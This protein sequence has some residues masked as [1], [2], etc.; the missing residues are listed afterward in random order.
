MGDQNQYDECQLV[1]R[2]RKGDLYAFDELYSK[3]SKKLLYFARGY[4]QSKEDAE[5]L[6]QEVFITIWEKR[7]TLRKDLCFD[8]Y[9]FT[10]TFNAIRKH[11]RS[12]SREKKHMERYSEEA[13]VNYDGLYSEIECNS[14][15]EIADNAI[16]KLP[17]KRQFI[18][19]LSREEGLSNEEIARKLNITKKTVENQ[20]HLSLK[21]LREELG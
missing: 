10:I 9:L 11:F 2:L 21:F 6:V 1:E 19:M 20:I 4:L 3:Y 15:R 12:R 7:K 18:Y 5:G 14:I 17:Q 16:K 13:P 8:A